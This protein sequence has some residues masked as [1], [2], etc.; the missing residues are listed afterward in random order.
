MVS[1]LSTRGTANVARSKR[2]IR[3]ERA[4]GCGFSARLAVYW[5]LGSACS[6][7]AAMGR[8]TCLPLSLVVPWGTADEE[9]VSP[10]GCAVARVTSSS[11]TTAEPSGIGT[12]P[13]KV[14]WLRIRQPS[15]P[16]TETVKYLGCD[17]HGRVRRPTACLIWRLGI[18]PYWTSGRLG[19][20]LPR[21]PEVAQCL[22]PCG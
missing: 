10:F 2:D 16:K 8:L 18:P 3:L 5:K 22:R 14:L 11:V 17:Q 21:C 13:S 19:I 4:S 9:A 20:A 12:S 1:A 6:K 15:P 7:N